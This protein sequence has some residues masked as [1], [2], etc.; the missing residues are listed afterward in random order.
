MQGRDSRELSSL[1]MS[2]LSTVALQKSPMQTCMLFVISQLFHVEAALQ[3]ISN[4]AM[5]QGCVRV[6]AVYPYAMTQ[7]TK[8]E[9]P[10]TGTWLKGFLMSK[11]ISASLDSFSPS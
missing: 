10:E 7:Q 5:T 3:F 4:H 11:L 2:L 9:S 1:E 8:Q 6:V